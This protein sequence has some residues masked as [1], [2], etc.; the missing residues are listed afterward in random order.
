MS[1]TIADFITQQ[2]AAYK[3][4][5]P[6]NQFW[7]WCM[8]DHIELSVLYKNSQLKTGK[9]EFKPVRNITRPLLNLQYRAEGFGVKDIQLYVNDS[10][11]YYKSLLVR[12]YHDKW[13]QDNDIDTFI[14]SLIESYIDFGGVL[15]KNV[16]DKKPEVVP[17]ESLAFCDQTDILSG[18]LA[19]KH[20]YSP[21][22]LLAMGAKGWGNPANGATATLKDVILLA[23]EEKKKSPN[24]AQTAKTPGKYIEVFEIHG[25]MP[26]S[27]I[28]SNDGSEEYSDQI[29]II[30]FYN[31]KNSQE[32]GFITLFKAKETK[33]PFKFLARDAIYGRALGLGGAEELFD[34]QVWT[35]YAMIR[36]QDMLDAASK[37]LLSSDDPAVTQKQKVRDMENMEVIELAPGTT[38]NQ[39]NTFPKNVALFE[40]A[41]QEWEQQA[42][43]MS[44]ASDALLGKQP[45]ANTPFALH[46]L[47]AQQ[48]Q[49]LHEYR[50][51]KL[52]TFLN[53]IY[54]DWIIPNIE[55]DIAHNQKWIAELDLDDLQMVSQNLVVAE[56]NKMVKGMILQGQIPTPDIQQQFQQL[57]QDEFK[58]KG[59]KHFLEILDG[60]FKN[61]D[62]GVEVNIASKQADLADKVNK[63]T[64]VFRTVIGSPY[65]LQSPPIAQLFNKIIEASGLDPIDLSN[66]KV[67]PMP[68][69]T[70]RGMIDYKDIQ[71]PKAQEE[72]LQLMG[73]EPNDT[74]YSGNV[75]QTENPA[76][77]PQQ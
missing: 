38:I 74:S 49:G 32:K 69:R 28:D 56:T 18:P 53:E 36:K 35:N 26:N 76:P 43:S 16:N 62:F 55:K 68:T 66:F 30:C 47:V 12:K 29:Q 27:F 4:S 3:Q 2:Q 14:N 25:T 5:I 23:R 71:D 31:K 67:P 41:I 54:R 77:T 60:E 1:E 37:T 39:I 19:I 72:Y 8:N 70:I 13:A 61:T 46:N 63:L 40:N 57:V 75:G 21:D 24:G 48:A 42:Q 65:I 59:S 10:K 58:K 33:S 45:T 22:Q 64:N 34:P 20:F 9:T 17:L 51:G 6:I 15:V 11:Q 73:I 7:D 50:K 44:G 52:A